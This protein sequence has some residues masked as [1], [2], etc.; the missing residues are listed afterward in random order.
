MS[1]VIQQLKEKLDTKM[2]AIVLHSDAELVALVSGSEELLNKHLGSECL[3]ELDYDKVIAWKEVPDFQ[4]ET[5]GIQGSSS[6]PN[7]ATLRGRVHNVMDIGD[8]TAIIDIYI[9][10]G[11]EFLSVESGELGNQTP[12]IGAGVEITV[13]NLCFYPTNT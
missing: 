6:Q 10:S 3:V 11:P 13:E 5:S 4:D 1:I 12:A 2:L 9:Q 7:A 8:Q